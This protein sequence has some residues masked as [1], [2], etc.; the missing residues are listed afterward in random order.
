[1]TRKQRSSPRQSTPA[2]QAKPI[3]L[4]MRLGVVALLAI[5][6]GAIGVVTITVELL[7]K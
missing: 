1:V 2:Q 7:V 3:V 5:P 6:V 4:L